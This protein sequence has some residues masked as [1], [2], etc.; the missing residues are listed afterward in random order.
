MRT[1]QRPRL[2]RLRKAA[3]S[4]AKAVLFL[5]VQ[6]AP[7][8]AQAEQIAQAQADG[9]EVQILEVVVV[10]CADSGGGNGADPERAA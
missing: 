8:P 1:P 4:V 9:R 7:T 5:V 2:E 6:G 3:A 10:P